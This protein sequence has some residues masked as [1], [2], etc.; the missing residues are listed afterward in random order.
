MVSE[1]VVSTDGSALG[2]PNGP[3]GWAWADHAKDAGGSP[4]HRHDG[5]GYGAGGATNGTNQ[6]GEL[7]AVLEALRAHPGPEPLR[8]ETDSQY[9][10]NCATKWVHGWKRNGWRNSQKKPVKNAAVI[11]AIDAEMSRRPGPVRFTWV[12]GHAGNAGNEL[13]DDLARTYAGDCRSGA[14]DGYLPLEG[15]QSLVASEYADGLDVPPDV[16]LALDSPAQATAGGGVASTPD[17]RTDAPGQPGPSPESAAEGGV[18]ADDSV[19]H[20]VKHP[21]NHNDDSVKQ[22]VEQSAAPASAADPTTGPEPTTGP[23]AESKPITAAEP[24]PAAATDDGAAGA[25]PSRPA[26]APELKDTGLRVSG[27]AVFAPAPRTSPT[28]TGEPIPVHG[29][30]EVSGHVDGD[31]R[32]TLDGARFLRR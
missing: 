3:M 10:I 17:S 30:I 14:Q 15:W 28:F 12:K 32:L 11:K 27:T 22:P 18:P 26:P 2:N 29:Y 23:A 13:V 8:I 9:A 31:G 19:E 20:P 21:V 24:V 16:Q 7:C 5:H 25:A 6:I 4:G 1:I